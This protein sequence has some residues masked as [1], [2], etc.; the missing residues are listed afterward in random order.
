MKQKISNYIYPERIFF[1]CSFSGILAFFIFAFHRGCYLFEWLNMENNSD[2]TMMDYFIPLSWNQDPKNTY[3]INHTYPPLINLCYYCI[4]KMTS[5]TGT[6][7]HSRGGAAVLSNMP[8]QM[9]VYS[10]YLVLGVFLIFFAI[11]EFQI[12]KKY[13]MGLC[14]AVLFSAPMFAGALE[15][16]NCVLYVVGFVLLA[17][18]WRDSDSRIK[19]EIAL[20]AIA[21][22]AGIKIYPAIIGLLYIRE[23]RYKEAVRLVIY[24]LL[25]IILPFAL[26]GGMESCRTF[27]LWLF[28]QTSAN[29][30]GRIQFFK[31]LFSLL[32]FGRFAD[33][34]YYVSVTILTIGIFV[35]ENRTRQASYAAGFM[36]MVPNGSYR[37]VL[38]F[39]LVPLMIL[40]VDISERESF[41]AY[42]DSICLGLLFSIPTFWGIFTG[43]E[44][45][46]GLYT[47]T[48]VEKYIYTIAYIYLFGQIIMDIMT[49]GRKIRWTFV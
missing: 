25:T 12:Q 21:L 39:F 36:A 19:R 24:G 1:F 20:L 14:I 29:Y 28:N 3:V 26:C 16:G 47:Y 49:V 38:L 13:K 8:Y 15:R 34:L 43:F 42:F 4:A 44:L 40:F 27:I 9:M 22:A 17:F 33:L 31:G 48:Y 7:D 23:K 6:I 32:G 45:N 18:A 11:S 30:E 35:S 10:L 41:E 2:W 46:Y 5:M 37:Y